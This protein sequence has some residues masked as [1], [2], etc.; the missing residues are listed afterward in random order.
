[1]RSAYGEPVFLN[2]GGT[3]QTS[4][5]SGNRYTYTGREQGEGLNSTTIGLGCMTR[6]VDGSVGGIRLGTQTAIRFS[7]LLEGRR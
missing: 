5:V 7:S 6:L 3:V 1:M 2:A 4:S